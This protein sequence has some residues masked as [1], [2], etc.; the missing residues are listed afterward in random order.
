MCALCILTGTGLSVNAAEDV[1]QKPAKEEIIQQRKARE[2][3]FEQ[4]L[5][6]TEAQKQRQK[7]FESKGVKG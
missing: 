4:K 2:A 3:A 7:N 1:V 6:L 5:G